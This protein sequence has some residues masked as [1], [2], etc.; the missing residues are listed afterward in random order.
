[1]PRL[2]HYVLLGVPQHTIQRGNNRQAIF[3]AD[4]DYQAYL[5]WLRQAAEQYGLHIHAS[6]LMTNHVHLLATPIA[7]DSIGKTLQSLGCRYVQCF[8]FSYGRTGTLW[9]SAIPREHSRRRKLFTGMQSIYRTEPA[10]SCHGCGS[11]HISLVQLSMQ[12][13]G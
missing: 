9:E 4:G 3:A 12:C 1:M 8:N 2:P 6:V 5:E 10:S 13:S 7:A 11:W